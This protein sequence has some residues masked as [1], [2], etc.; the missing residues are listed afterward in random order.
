METI[1]HKSQTILQ[2]SDDLVTLSF[3]EYH[4]Y[5]HNYIA[6]KINS[7]YDA[8]DLAQDVFVRL[9]DYK[10]MLRPETVKSFLFTIA[11]NLVIDYLRRQTKKQEV[12]ANYYESMPAFTREVESNLYA[13]ELTKLEITKLKTFS[14]QRKNVYSLFRYEDLSVTEISEQLSLSVRTVENHLYAGRKIIRNYIR[15]CI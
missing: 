2:S 4:V 7:R 8:E 10:L 6:S 14:P 13:K 3:N 12:S 1:G 15:K 9:L 5:I 11:H